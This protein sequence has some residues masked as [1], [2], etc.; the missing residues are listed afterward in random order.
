MHLIEHRVHQ[1]NGSVIYKSSQLGGTQI[2]KR[3]E[4]LSLNS[5]KVLRV[6]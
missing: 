1:Q 2:V 4:R 3:R 5:P 6:D